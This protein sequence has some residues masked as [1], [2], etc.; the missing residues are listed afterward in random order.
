MTQSLIPTE[1]EVADLVVDDLKAIL[2]RDDLSDAQFV[3][4]IRRR[5]AMPDAALI[6]LEPEGGEQ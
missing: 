4:E 2:R 1:N 5:L 3:E 6:V